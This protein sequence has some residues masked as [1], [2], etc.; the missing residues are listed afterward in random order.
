MGGV[1][2][3]LRPDPAKGVFETFL[4]VEGVLIEL[5]SHFARLEASVTVL[6]GATL[7]D[8]TREAVEE[9]AR[10]MALGRLRVTLAPIG[11]AGELTREIVTAEVDPALVFPSPERA[12]IAHS[13]LVEGGL[14]SHK[15]ADR[16]LIGEAESELGAGEVPLL[17]DRG[18]V[19]LEASRANVFAIRGETL[20]TPPADGRLLPGIARRR[21]M[22]AA[23]ACGLLPHE[24]ELTI[25]DLAKADEVLLAGSVRGIEPVRAIDDTELGR[26]S[27]ASARV[28]AELR[29]G[30]M[31]SQANVY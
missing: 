6:F 1:P 12:V 7:S 24:T 29:R 30:W 28:A 25:D 11:E 13:V 26:P 18:G 17:V 3:L 4:V 23:D 27:N 8:E 16:D 31:P 19:V 2:R 22:E 21:V 14:G 10:G 20:V 5:E 15:W 9:H